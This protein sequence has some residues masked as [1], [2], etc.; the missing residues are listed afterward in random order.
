MKVCFGTTWYIIL[1]FMV[2]ISR[3]IRHPHSGP[4]FP[5][6]KTDEAVG[7]ENSLKK[8]FST[9]VSKA[10][11]SCRASLIPTCGIIMHGRN[12]NRDLESVPI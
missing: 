7:K 6:A 1:V 9:T 4:S 10:A 11:K 12:D 8:D 5:V 3:D 2:E